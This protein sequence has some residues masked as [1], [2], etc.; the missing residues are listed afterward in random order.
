[1]RELSDT[2]RQ[3]ILDAAL[4][5]FV[6]QHYHGTAIPEIARR[7]GVADGTIYRYFKNKQDL[8]NAL[9]KECKMAL[10]ALLVAPFSPGLS[11]R[12]R[13]NEIAARFARYAEN[14]RREVCFLEKNHHESYLED[15]ARATEQP[16]EAFVVGLLEE[17]KAQG[18]VK[19]LPSALLFSILYSGLLGAL[20]LERQGRIA[21]FQAV[22]P[23]VQECLWHAIRA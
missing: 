13:L 4:E 10:V 2:K 18:L 9:Y 12:E 11:L 19:Q 5:L 21:S 20:E 1:M 6:T 23:D 14:H 8:V 22:L 3:A 7:A 17:G 15:D 16:L